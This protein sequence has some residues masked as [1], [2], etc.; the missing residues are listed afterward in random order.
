[1]LLSANTGKIV[2]SINYR[3]DELSSQNK[4][5]VES[6]IQ[7]ENRKLMANAPSPEGSEHLEA[8]L[9]P[10]PTVAVETGNVPS[11]QSIPVPIPVILTDG[12]Y[13]AL[14]PA[15][16][17][18][19]ST[20]TTPIV[21]TRKK[22]KFDTPTPTWRTPMS[23]PRTSPSVSTKTKPNDP[24]TPLSFPSQ[25]SDGSVYEAPSGQRPPIEFVSPIIKEA[26]P[27]RLFSAV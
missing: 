19:P 23:M 21:A 27:C 25:G 22:L 8:P 10:P 13:K 12:Q 7:G 26:T 20:E 6:R 11:V 3:V 14:P 9:P 1:M 17:T 18:V 15:V 4:L 2:S 5:F 24:R 16:A